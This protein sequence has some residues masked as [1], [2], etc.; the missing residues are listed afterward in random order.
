MEPDTNV[1]Y[2]CQ[3]CAQKQT[4]G[5]S[6]GMCFSLCC[7][8]VLGAIEE[9][10]LPGRRQNIPLIGKKITNSPMIPQILPYKVCAVCVCVCAMRTPGLTH[11]ASF[12]L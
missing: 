11:H 4:S 3:L 8:R 9:A 1:S 6:Q 10:V 5:C 2:L 12:P 7:D